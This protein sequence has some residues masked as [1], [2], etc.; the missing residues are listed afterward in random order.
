MSLRT[1]GN[2]S[3]DGLAPRKFTEVRTVYDGNITYICFF[4]EG[5]V[6]KSGIEMRVYSDGKDKLTRVFT[7]MTAPIQVLLDAQDWS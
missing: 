7:E 2:L 1:G 6:F 5:N 3:L 4:Q